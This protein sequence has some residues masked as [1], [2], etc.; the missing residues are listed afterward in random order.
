M[1]RSLTSIAVAGSFATT[2]VAGV[3]MAG[4]AAAGI[5]P[6]RL[7]LTITSGR[8]STGSPATITAV[9]V[10]M[11]EKIQYYINI[12]QGG[13]EAVLRTCTTTRCKVEVVPPLGHTTYWADISAVRGKPRVG[14]T[15]LRRLRIMNIGN[16]APGAA[17]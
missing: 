16:C 1:K 7:S 2:A 11:T 10:G 13:H 14:A 3:H 6:H 15:V 9:S 17:C 5:N 12:W 4:P 8:W